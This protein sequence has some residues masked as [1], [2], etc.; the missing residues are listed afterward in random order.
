MGLWHLAP[1]HT[2]AFPLPAVL[3]LLEEGV[4][5]L[6][7]SSIS[8]C[9]PH[10]DWS[11]PHKGG[12]ILRAFQAQ[13][14]CPGTRQKCGKLRLIANSVIGGVC[15]IRLP[16]LSRIICYS[17]CNVSAINNCTIVTRSEPKFLSWQQRQLKLL[18]QT[19]QL[20]L[21]PSRDF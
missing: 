17:K 1:F 6:S 20:H 7:S 13:S 8:L 21:Y 18:P 5:Q 14:L 11:T 4:C 10:S 15:E 19:C 2:L 9:A 3:I 12:D 16:L